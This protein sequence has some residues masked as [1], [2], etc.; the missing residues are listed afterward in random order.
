[1]TAES[2][3]TRFDEFDIAR[4]L[5]ILG[6]PITHVLEEFDTD[7]VL[8]SGFVDAH[9]YLLVLAP[10]GAALFM[11]CMGANMVFTHRSSPRDFA[12]RG[13][14][15]LI[16]GMLLNLVRFALPDIIFGHLPGGTYTGEWPLLALSS[17][18]YDF[19][20]GCF[21]V[22][23]L[24]RKF[25]LSPRQ[26]LVIAALCLVT[27][28]YLLPHFF[29]DSSISMLSI[30]L[31]RFFWVNEYS[32]FPLLTWLFFPA[33]GFAFGNWFKD[34]QTDEAREA[35]LRKMMPVAALVF[36][37]TAL[38]VIATGGNLILTYASPVNSYITDIPNVALVGSS[39]VFVAA[40][41]HKLTLALR[42]KRV[43]AWFIRTSRG[44]IPYYACQWVIVGWAEY[45]I[46]DLH[47]APYV[48]LNEIGYW[49][50]SI[51]ILL[52]SLRYARFWLAFKARHQRPQSA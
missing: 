45:A 34:V 1:M 43:L 9:I 40:G 38:G 23:A 20:G 48:H 47:L 25:N 29:A 28:A 15:L 8:P 35:G 5:A 51:A 2:Q 27:G 41:V 42:G 26:I 11:A 6:L 49:L 7:G 16:M 32:Y 12:G 44:I 3:R 36:C 24:F 19:S 18:I 22:F 37:V 14:R 52:I 50:V 10:L 13:V 31:G 39:L 17:D 30:F 33:M 4:A 21:I 46:Y